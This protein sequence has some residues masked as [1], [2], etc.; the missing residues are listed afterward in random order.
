MIS[1]QSLACQQRV[2]SDFHEHF[3][4]LMEQL[5]GRRSPE[6]RLAAALAS[7]STEAGHVC[8]HLAEIAGRPLSGYGSELGGV[9]PVAP[10]LMHW[11]EALRTSGVV[12]EPG[13]FRPLI[14]DRRNRLYLYR[15]WDYE[16]R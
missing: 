9:P 12:G 3:S 5:S 10:A 4:K 16:C 1:A 13:E 6:L 8:L 14:L 11:I 7:S 2:V 15:Y